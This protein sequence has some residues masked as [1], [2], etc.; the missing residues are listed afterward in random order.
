M[1]SLL[2][3]F[4]IVFVFVQLKVTV[5]YATTINLSEL[6]DFLHGR[7]SSNQASPREGLRSL[8][9]ILRQQPSLHYMAVGHSFYPPPGELNKPLPLGG[10]CEA[11]FGMY[12]A[13]RP[14]QWKVLLVNID[15]Q[16]CEFFNIK[17]L[18]E[19]N[20]FFIRTFF[21]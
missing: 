5:K 16:S 7:L 4:A 8:D 18:C 15:G 10:G 17:L 11:W 14:S 3:N 9:I 13:V 12:Q 2:S 6:M 1:E 19:L 21:L 20:F